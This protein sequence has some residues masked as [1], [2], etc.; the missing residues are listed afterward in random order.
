MS[1]ELEGFR[2]LVQA[3]KLE[4]AVSLAR[5]AGR[6]PDGARHPRNIAAGGWRKADAVR[7]AD[8]HHANE[9]AWVPVSLAFYVRL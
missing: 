7:G 5:L 9:A 6:D 1:H 8:D 4:R 3:G 2:Q